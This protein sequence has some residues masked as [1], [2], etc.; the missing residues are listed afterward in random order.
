M[1]LLSA[2][3][4]VFSV[5]FCG[6]LVLHGNRELSAQMKT[7]LDGQP[8]LC[9]HVGQLKSVSLRLGDS[10]ALDRDNLLTYDVTGTQGTAALTVE[11][12]PAYDGSEII[13]WAEMVLPSGQ[14][15]EVVRRRPPP[16]SAELFGEDWDEEEWDAEA[17]GDVLL[18]DDEDLDPETVRRVIEE[19]RDG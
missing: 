1:R 7:Q 11:Q 16:T 14:T 5:V 13:V 4:T 17:D 2:L 19:L 8:V 10:L 15:I 9:S 12:Y 3:G 6:A 18:D